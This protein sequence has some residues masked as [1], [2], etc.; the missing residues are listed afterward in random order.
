MQ[1][2]TE[3]LVV[4]LSKTNRFEGVSW[5]CDETLI[6]YVAEEPE[7][8]KPTFNNFGYES[9]SIINKGC[10]NWKGQGN[11]EEGWGE[12]YTNRRRPTVFV[13][14]INRF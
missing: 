5:N 8:R 3:M 11:W 2:I 12:T 9:A 6:A 13:I 10:N 14:N 1:A 4:P 7:P